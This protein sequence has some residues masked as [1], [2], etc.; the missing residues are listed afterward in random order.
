MIYI[1]THTPHLHIY[2]YIHTCIRTQWIGECMNQS[3]EQ[4]DPLAALA[5]CLVRSIRGRVQW[6]GMKN[7]RMIF[8]RWRTLGDAMRTD[9]HDFPF[10]LYD[11][12]SLLFHNF[13]MLQG[14]TRS[15]LPVL[16]QEH[17]VAWGGDRVFCKTQYSQNMSLDFACCFRPSFCNVSAVHWTYLDCLDH[18]QCIPCA[19][20]A[21][22]HHVPL[23]QE[24]AVTD[25]VGFEPGNTTS[26]TQTS[27]MV[28]MVAIG[29]APSNPRIP[30]CGGSWRQYL[31][32]NWAGRWW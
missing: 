31:K 19:Y 12:P 18:E 28:A 8:A 24:I 4:K 32:C 22:S 2:I 5:R 9:L 25:S 21:G 17:V 7:T 29:A 16:V 11:T 27:Q 10:Y 30:N 20:T 26:A 1:Y 3:A 13:T 23:N 15:Q 6:S 14:S